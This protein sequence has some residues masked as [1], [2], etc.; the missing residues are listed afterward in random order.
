MTWTKSDIRAARQVDLAPILASRG[1]RLQSLK[2][3]NYGIVPDQVH[4]PLAGLVVKRKYWNW[5][6][7]QKAGNTIDL[8]VKIDRLTFHQAMEII[9]QTQPL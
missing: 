8:L 9:T 5:P 2:N 4:T 6:D 7:H 1:Y 3:D